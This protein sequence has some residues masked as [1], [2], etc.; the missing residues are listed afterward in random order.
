[1]LSTIIAHLVA[2]KNREKSELLTYGSLKK[3]YDSCDIG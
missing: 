1:M 2:E 3:L